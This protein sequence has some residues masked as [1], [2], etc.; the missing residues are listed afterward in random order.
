MLFALIFCA[1]LTFNFLSC[2]IAFAQNHLTAE[3]YEED[4]DFLW[5]T[6]RADYAYFDE[7][8]TDWDRVKEIYRPEIKSISTKSEFI[9][10]VEQVL[11]ELYDDHIHL[12]THT[13]FSPNIVPSRTDIWAEWTDGRAIVMGI[14]SGFP[15]DTAGL[16]PGMEILR[17][18]GMPIEDAVR[19]RMGRAIVEVDDDIKDWTLRKVLAGFRNQNRRF[20]FRDQGET[21]LVSIPPEPFDIA[22]RLQHQSKLDFQILGDRIGYVAINGTLVDNGL[23]KSFDDALEE[24]PETDGLILDL[25]KVGGGNT[26]VVEGII[27]RLIDRERVYQ[28]TVPRNGEPY[29][30]RVRPRGRWQ[31]ANPVVI[32]VNRWT[33]SA[34]EGLAISLDALDRA[35]VVGTKMAGL[36]GS[37]LTM[38]MPNSGIGFQCTNQKIFNGT[39]KGDAASQE[40]VGS[41]RRAYVPSLLVDPL[42]VSWGESEDPILK[43]GVD[44]LRGIGHQYDR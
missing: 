8:R 32:L 34:G 3:Q 11:D 6:F 29:L 7:K 10:M 31:Y 25:R 12:N 30:S 9:A 42:K 28:R 18:N 33:G 23:L 13:A 2:S 41:S 16:R 37:V 5:E 27:G 17:F 38:R 14:R 21:R 22:D 35:T 15:A 43:R 40:F 1:L 39:L 44:V 20:E 19:K 4:F 36:E 24:L 26:G